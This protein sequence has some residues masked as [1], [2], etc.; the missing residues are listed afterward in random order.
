MRRLLAYFIGVLAVAAMPLKAAPVPVD[1]Q[2]PVV[3][4]VDLS[5]GQ[6]LY[7]READRRFMPASV[8][9]VMTAYT[10]FELVEAGELSL[11]RPVLYT[12]ALERE[13]YAE[14]STMFL[15]AGETP[16]VGQ[17]LLGIS[18]VSGNDA[19]VA[20]ALEAKGSLEAWLA[21]M[22]DN[23]QKLGMTS[24]HFGSPNGYPD[25]GRTYTTANDLALLGR[26]ITQDHPG[27]YR[28]FFGHSFLTWGGFTQ[29]NHDPVTGRV[30]GADG[31]KTGFTNEAGFTFLG[32]AQRDGRRLII[33]LAGAPTSELRD[34]ASRALLEWGFV[35]FSHHRVAAAGKPVAQALVQD[36]ARASVALVAPDD[37]TIA[38]PADVVPDALDLKV[39]YRG[40][41]SAPIAAGDKIA[42][43]TISH[44]G[45]TMLETPLMA[46]DKV[47]KANVFQRIGNAFA[48]WFA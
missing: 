4:L 25:G 13:W 14:G 8:T 42:M 33:V 45:E 12:R 20:L 37:I 30:A 18:T 46:R 43:L 31:I 16:S 1:R 26:A 19:S 38:L 44:R 21:A 2:V 24:T 28:R 29:K 27:L 7:A 17:L 10:A 40:P 35:N 3:L 48:G 15:R 5:N 9:K 39:T 11:D 22:N 34:E 6:T 36:G 23:A 32:S 41:L 47:E